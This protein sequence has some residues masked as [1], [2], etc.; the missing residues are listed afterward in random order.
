LTNEFGRGPHLGF[1]L[2]DR[3][4]QYGEAI[5]QALQSLG[6]DPEPLRRRVQTFGRDLIGR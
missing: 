6:G 4:G 2:F 3:P 5:G 1:D